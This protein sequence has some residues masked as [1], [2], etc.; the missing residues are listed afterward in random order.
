MFYVAGLY[1]RPV[2]CHEKIRAPAH[3]CANGLFRQCGDLLAT[4]VIHLIPGAI[5]LDIRNLFLCLHAYSHQQQ[6]HEC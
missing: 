4:L 5:G 1:P 2:D 3:H 6:H